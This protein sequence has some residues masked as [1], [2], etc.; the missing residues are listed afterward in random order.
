MSETSTDLA[1]I[2]PVTGQV[3]NL[4]DYRECSQALDS[5]RDIEADLRRIKAE[6]CRA[7]AFEAERQGTKSLPLP[8]GRKAMLSG[9]VETTYDEQKMEEGLRAAG[10]PEE[11]IREIVVE[12]VSYKVR[13]VE[14]KRAASANAEYAFVID[15]ARVELDTPVRVSIRKA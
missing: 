13:A 14:A 3:V 10:M 7:I 11:R 6:L 15:G 2:V 8:D 9:G 12:E 5:I 1:I 4:E